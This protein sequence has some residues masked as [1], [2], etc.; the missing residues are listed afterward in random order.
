M[1]NRALRFSLCLLVTP[2]GLAS[3]QD[4]FSD[5]IIRADKPWDAATKNTVEALLMNKAGVVPTYI[6]GGQK[7]GSIIG[8]QCPGAGETYLDQA[9]DR[10]ALLNPEL[11]GGTS[12]W[13]LD[14]VVG[15]TG[16][17]ATVYLP[18]C[19]GADAS[20]HVV[21]GADDVLWNL[22]V[23]QADDSNGIVDWGVFQ[24]ETA[25]I[26]GFE[27][28]DT[29]QPGQYIALPSPQLQVTVPNVYASDL[30]KALDQVNVSADLVPLSFGTLQAEGQPD[31]K[32]SADSELDSLKHAE[33]LLAELTNVFLYNDRIDD[34][35]VGRERER[36]N[37]RIGVFDSGME[38]M[39]GNDGLVLS[40]LYRPLRD[41]V[42]DADVMPLPGYAK[43]SH[44]TIV[45]F[46][47]LGGP[48]FAP[49]TAL[50]DTMS[51]S[52]IRLTQEVCF[53]L[54]DGTRS[55]CQVGES[56]EILTD[57]VRRTMEDGA[58]AGANISVSFPPG[59]ASLGDFGTFVGADKR[60]LIVV[61]AGNEGKLVGG[62]FKN[63]PA[64]FGGNELS[65]LITV[66]AL[67]RDGSRLDD[68][69]YSPSKVDIGA[70]GC[71]VPVLGYDQQT[72]M[73]KQ[74]FDS[75][76]SIAAPQVLFAAMMILREQWNDRDR[77]R[78]TQVKMRLAASSDILVDLWGEVK[79]GRQLNI[80]KALS[81]HTDL[82]E[83]QDGRIDR[84]RLSFADEKPRNVRLCPDVEIALEDLMKISDLG[85][86]I[87][88]PKDTKRY[89][90]YS[91]DPSLPLP[92]QRGLVLNWCDR[93]LPSV[94][95]L[96]PLTG[97]ERDVPFT[98]IKDLV[99]AT[100]PYWED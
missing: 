78:P 46:A 93:I 11:G 19:L 55:Q 95:L 64:A 21:K 13:T 7:L 1:W 31:T 60:L 94:H 80:T 30:V 38:G 77:L 84:G 61:A 87:E 5:L 34:L 9:P 79:H 65:N 49:M 57:N 17:Q 40:H 63:L 67:K 20:K 14:T 100:T 16:K 91:F 70:W 53:R 97:V 52:P 10:T 39:R 59:T 85:S 44:G 76:T 37:I 35:A 22:Y 41:S 45:A 83:L 56:A 8:R 86:D 68:S 74:T 98:N 24:R 12:T 72:G 99:M 23:D 69:N 75:G 25:R 88:L 33:V 96:D 54:P 32:C 27:V 43:A 50:L 29:L 4:V 2:M 15:E 81:L 90:V 28:N 6:E 73:F 62:S 48:L 71:N 36:D 82:I 92:E 26:N 66:A 18:Y 42:T 47:A 89:L 58:V 51:V 3:A